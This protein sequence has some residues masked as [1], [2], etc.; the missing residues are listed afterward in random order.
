MCEY[1]MMMLMAVLA[2]DFG[3]VSVVMMPIMVIMPMIVD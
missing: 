2:F 1:F 3:V